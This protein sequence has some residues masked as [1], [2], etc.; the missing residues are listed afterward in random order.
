MNQSCCK[1]EWEGYTGREELVGAQRK[2][3]R[4][5]TGSQCFLCSPGF[6]ILWVLSECISLQCFSIK[7]KTQGSYLNISKRWSHLFL[8]HLKLYLA[9]MPQTLLQSSTWHPNW[10]ERSC[11]SAKT[12]C[13]LPPASCGKYLPHCTLI[14]LTSLNPSPTF[15]V[16]EDRDQVS[17]NSLVP[18]A[19][20]P[21]HQCVLIF[22]RFL[23]PGQIK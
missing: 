18:W 6:F 9:N 1:K 11:D 19:E 14:F 12:P 17:F 21:L 16:N 3:G 2:S 7:H 22:A 4:F 10:E 15:T 5:V 20:S 8:P 13:T 23:V